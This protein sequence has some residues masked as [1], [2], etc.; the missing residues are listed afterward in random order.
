MYIIASLILICAGTVVLTNTATNDNYP[1][2]KK[3]EV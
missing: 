3:K 1:K 2:T